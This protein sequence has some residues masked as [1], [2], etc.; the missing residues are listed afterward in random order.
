[1][2]RVAH[3]TLAVLAMTACDLNEEEA[4]NPDAGVDYVTL[5]VEASTAGEGG[6]VTMT[7]A[8]CTNDADTGFFEANFTGPNGSAMNVKIKGF[9]TV[10]RSYECSQALDNTSGEIGN[11][12]DGCALELTIPDQAT[13][14][15]TYA[16]HRGSLDV[17]DFTYT[18]G[19]TIST[20]YEAPRVTASVLCTSLVQT[21]FQGALRNPVDPSVTADLVEE[22]SFF[23]DL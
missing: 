14:T 20:S 10:A 18:G 12:Y 22:S 21:H 7:T 11:K 5:Q 19:C 16:M 9:A 4:P 3:L 2:K 17:R 6:V 13:A 8:A 15:N 23:C 1:M